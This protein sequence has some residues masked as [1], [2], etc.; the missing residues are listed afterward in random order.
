MKGSSDTPSATVPVSTLRSQR[1]VTHEPVP[2]VDTQGV[3]WPQAFL[4]AAYVAT[5]AVLF[6]LLEEP[7]ES[8]V[9]FGAFVLLFLLIGLAFGLLIGRWWALA[10]ALAVV[11]ISAPAWDGDCTELCPQDMALFVELPLTALGLAVGV[12]ARNAARKRTRHPAAP[13][14]S[15]KPRPPGA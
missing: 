11:P 3:T 1:G 15:R 5:A 10:L 8:A 9:S 14:Q 13:A 7:V 12:V 6:H 2:A 4:A